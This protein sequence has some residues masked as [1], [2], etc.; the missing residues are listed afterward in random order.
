M[1]GT[2]R[3]AALT[4]SVALLVTTG[5]Q[6]GAP[7]QDVEFLRG[8]WV[9]K[10][11]PGGKVTG[12]LRLLPVTVDSP[13]YEGDV[14]V[15]MGNLMRSTMRLSFARDG[16]TMTMTRVGGGQVLPADPTA[17]PVELAAAPSDAFGE[18]LPKS[19]HRATYANGQ[20]AMSG[21]VAES[22]GEDIAIYMMAGGQRAADLFRGER[23]GCD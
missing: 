3:I 12:F 8:C 11:A 10:E 21:I 16:S 6:T 4:C 22:E 13:T 19:K 14:Q 1:A 17:Q 15:L 18:E 9:A 2:S 5:C 20:P 23:D 7:K